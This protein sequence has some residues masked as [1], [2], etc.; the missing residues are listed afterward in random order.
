[1]KKIICKK[2]NEEWFVENGKT[3]KLQLCPFCGV[4]LWEKE[5]MGDL[6]NTTMENAL[7]N[8][9][10]RSGVEVLKQKSRVIGMLSDLTKGMDKEIRIISRA[11]NQDIANLVYSAFISEKAVSQTEL[12]RIKHSLIEDEGFA[13]SWAMFFVNSI[14]K[15]IQLHK[16]T[17]SKKQN[18]IISEFGMD[19]VQ[20]LPSKERT[21][22]LENELSD[23]IST[24]F[25]GVE[26]VE[27]AALKESGITVDED[28]K[29][30]QDMIQICTKESYKYDIDRYKNLIDKDIELL[31]M[32]L[33]EQQ[34]INLLTK[35]GNI[36]FEGGQIQNNKK[37]YER[38]YY[39]WN[40]A[41]ELAG[42][43]GANKLEAEKGLFMFF[44]PGYIGIKERKNA[45]K[46]KS[47]GIL[48]AKK[49]E[50]EV[51]ERLFKWADNYGMSKKEAEE[52]FEE[53]EQDPEVS[54]SKILSLIDAYCNG[55][56]EMNTRTEIISHN[57]RKAEKW[58]DYLKKND[59]KLMND[60]LENRVDVIC[61]LIDLYAEGNSILHPDNEKVRYWFLE[62]KKLDD[63]SW[64]KKIWPVE[65]FYLTTDFEK[66]Y[67]TKKHSTGGGF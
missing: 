65:D 3:E 13:E 30:I 35:L 27:P 5:I 33:E 46:A 2:C 59:I 26:D 28:W 12:K 57:Y 34:N 21:G 15:C 6:D 18:V 40:K 41:I 36:F 66:E 42:E 47:I 20:L 23:N 43:T 7:F 67:E 54:I 55:I 63:E 49:G 14:Q 9:V 10:R 37:D 64:K 61:K 8:I 53:I 19:T 51:F 45:I 62:L 52:V 11:Y 39:L 31:I 16:G 24:M 38:A 25:E 1:M 32:W 22:L 4:N 29:K 17:D 50:R 60:C 48:L 56:I 58:Y 44:S